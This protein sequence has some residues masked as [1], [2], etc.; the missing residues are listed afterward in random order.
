MDSGAPSGRRKDL[1]MTRRWARIVGGLMATLLACPVARASTGDPMD[2]TS[3]LI[4][5]ADVV[6]FLR[7]RVLAER[8]ELLTDEAGQEAAF[9]AELA[10]LDLD[11]PEGVLLDVRVDDLNL[12]GLLLEEQLRRRRTAR[13]RS[14]VAEAEDA[15]QLSAP[16][17]EEEVT[18]ESSVVP[19]VVRL[20]SAIHQHRS[21]VPPLPGPHPAGGYPEV[22]VARD[23]E[24]PAAEEPIAKAPAPKTP[25]RE[26]PVAK[27]TSA[28]A[29]A[30]PASDATDAALAEELAE[31]G[32]KLRA[33]L[34][35][36]DAAAPASTDPR[37][38]DRSHRVSGT[39]RNS[40]ASPTRRSERPK[41]AEVPEVPRIAQ[42]E[43]DEPVRILLES[44]PRG[45]DLDTREMAVPVKDARVRPES[46]A[47]PATERAA[48][49]P[50]QAEAPPK[51]AAKDS[52]LPQED[53]VAAVLAQVL[54]LVQ[55]QEVSPAE[56]P[57]VMSATL[58]TFGVKVPGDFRPRPEDSPE[59]MARE[60]L[61]TSGG[62]VDVAMAA[63][64]LGI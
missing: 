23:S 64:A 41:L 40:G 18:G 63:A 26:A 59:A 48:A 62:Q 42:P 8:P 17:P 51:P 7:R 39:Q 35:R 9:R 60:L 55:G 30:A 47:A 45:P 33:A 15:F 27:V 11:P 31:V 3:E 29:S 24:G 54:P 34:A 14:L 12:A 13:R 44:A 5:L 16:S 25:T 46:R 1:F 38:G 50:P 4:R 53:G 43:L 32:A 37:Y 58:S 20:F 6:G 2:T 56:F 36:V 49:A 19:E 52:R 61:A 57:R 21:K 10:R 22:E 28:K